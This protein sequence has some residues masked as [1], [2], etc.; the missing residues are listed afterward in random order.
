MLKQVRPRRT[1]SARMALE[2]LPWERRRPRLMLHIFAGSAGVLAW[3]LAGRPEQR[4]II[5]LICAKY[6]AIFG[7][8]VATGSLGDQLWPT[9]K[10][11]L[12]ARKPKTMRH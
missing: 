11:A 1:G 5:C 6:A 3:R 9:R 7:V 2:K 12:P 10:P 8:F 4:A